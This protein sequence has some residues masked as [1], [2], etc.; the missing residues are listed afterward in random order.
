MTETTLEAKK[1]ETV[2]PEK[3]ESIRPRRTLSPA[4]D[5][6][7][8]DDAIVL[9]VNMPGVPEENVDITLEKNQL[10]IRGKVD[11]EAPE[12]YKAVYGEYA[13]GDYKRSFSLSD[14]VN[15]D[16]I[17]ATLK[18]GVLRLVLAKAADAKPRQIAVRAG[19]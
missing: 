1:E 7:E 10:S 6:F 9:L 5:I 8:T 4:I 12:G 19:N 3:A 13:V 14:E 15:R 18:H 17:E 16:E 2:A 11:H